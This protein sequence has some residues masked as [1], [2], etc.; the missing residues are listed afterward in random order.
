MN[1][2]A[3]HGKEVTSHMRSGRPRPGAS[4]GDEEGEASVGDAAAHLTDSHA[5]LTTNL[6]MH[7]S[8]LRREAY[9]QRKRSFTSRE[10]GWR[11]R[12]QG[13]PYV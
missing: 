10:I 3:M 9:N 2:I 11:A 8:S 7:Q 6:H 12:I 13:P 1:A 5:H 4:A